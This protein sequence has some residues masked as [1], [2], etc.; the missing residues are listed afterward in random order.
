MI[1]K[2]LGLLDLFDVVV[3]SGAVG[4]R[5]P[6]PKIV[7]KTMELMDVKTAVVIGDKLTHD[8][9]CANKAGVPF[10]WMRLKPSGQPGNIKAI[11]NSSICYKS[12]I[13]SL[14]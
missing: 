6:D 11:N 4:L 9:K 10:L 14:S 12:A 3:I 5:K 2:K 7:E 13:I 8:G 1:L